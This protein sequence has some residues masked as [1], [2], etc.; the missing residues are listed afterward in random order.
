M[1][2]YARFTPLFSVNK[3]FETRNKYSLSAKLMDYKPGVT[4]TWG[5]PV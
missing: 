1:Y 3:V 2:A 5:V 4:R